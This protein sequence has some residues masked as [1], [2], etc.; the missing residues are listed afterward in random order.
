A[1][2]MN[3]MINDFSTQLSGLPEQLNSIGANDSDS[4][5]KAKQVLTV[6]AKL[7]E[8]QQE[9]MA[10]SQE[11]LKQII[12][13]SQ[14]NDE[15]LK[16]IQTIQKTVDGAKTKLNN[17]QKSLTALSGMTKQI[18]QLSANMSGDDTAM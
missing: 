8:D 3:T 11:D 13:N 18:K 15:T 16:N 12:K 5:T 7:P 2:E 9:Q 17:A 1:A 10:G 4:A 6:I 14:E